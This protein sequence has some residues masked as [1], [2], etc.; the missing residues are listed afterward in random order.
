MEDLYMFFAVSMLVKVYK[1]LVTGVY[2]YFLHKS[3]LNRFL[4]FFLFDRLKLN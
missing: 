3:C 4:V 2:D 1:E